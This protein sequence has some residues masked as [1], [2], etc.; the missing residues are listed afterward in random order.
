MKWL[1]RGRLSFEKKMTLEVESPPEAFESR[2]KLTQEIYSLFAE[3]FPALFT[4]PS[5]KVEENP[6]DD[7][8]KEGEENVEEG[9]PG[10]GSPAKS[11][12][13]GDGEE[14]GDGSA[15]PSPKKPE[16]VVMDVYEEKIREVNK[17]CE[18]FVS[19]V[20]ELETH[21]REAQQRAEE[22]EQAALTTADEL[23]TPQ[24]RDTGLPEMPSFLALNEEKLDSM[25]LLNPQTLWETI[26]AVRDEKSAPPRTIEYFENEAKGYLKTTNNLRVRSKIL[27]QY[28][29]KVTYKSFLGLTDQE[30]IKRAKESEMRL[31]ELSK[32]MSAAQWDEEVKILERMKLKLNYTQ[33][34]RYVEE[35]K[36]GFDKTKKGK[37]TPLFKIEPD[38]IEFGGYELG[39]MY[40][41]QVR[42]RNVS[43]L[44]R[45]ARFLLPRSKY[46]SIDKVEFPGS[47]NLLA[48]GMCCK[49]ELYFMPDSLADYDD[50]FSI[51][52][53]VSTFQVQVAARR[54]SSNLSVPKTFDCGPCLLGHTLVTEFPCINSGGRG[55]FKLV[56]E[57]DWPNSDVDV[58]TSGAIEL[59]PFTFEPSSFKLYP[60]DEMIIKIAFLPQEA[61]NFI[62]KFK[63]LCDNCKIEDF[64]IVGLG[65]K[66]DITLESVDGKTFFEEEKTYETPVETGNLADSVV[67]KRKVWFGEVVPGANNSRTIMVRNNTP[68][69]L[70][71]HWTL[72]ENSYSGDALSKSKNIFQIS[73]MSGV[74]GAHE[75]SEFMFV[76]EPELIE[77]YMYTAQLMIESHSHTSEGSLLNKVIELDLEGSGKGLDIVLT[78]ALLEFN[79]T[80]LFGKQYERDV[81]IS[82]HSKAPAHFC[83]KNLPPNVSVFPKTALV[84]AEDAIECD[85]T[86]VA[87]ELGRTD[88]TLINEIEHGPQLPLRV[89]Y[90]VDGPKVKFLAPQIDFGLVEETKPVKASFQL[91]NC[92]DTQAEFVLK[93]FDLPSRERKD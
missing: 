11:T 46:F 1:A 14:E 53:D 59:V 68:I 49:C 48:P 31:K 57:E 66:L 30:L 92:S 78:P 35:K 13:E 23:Y 93:E 21:L 42:V 9:S 73:P 63:M 76:F 39:G 33:N 44:S 54:P 7:Q 75:N 61:G 38:N 50:F 12:E 32:K 62:R 72:N 34:P 88:I 74:L 2:S 36:V 55:A 84:P 3:S 87:S 89:V 79:G 28:P 52:T 10:K 8:E 69:P 43:G 65:V 77:S 90:N 29:K 20:C 37:K 40:S 5:E 4:E 15:E 67:E 27:E 83:W 6:E 82:N 47:K 56:R 41:M 45:R 18:D 81:T 22:E 26:L 64:S 24:W 60:E 71:Y 80:M 85:I 70:A 25:N 51:E 17:S 91:Q 16:E 58:S 19:F 86:V